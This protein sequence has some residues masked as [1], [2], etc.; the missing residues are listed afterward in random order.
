MGDLAQWVGDLPCRQEEPEFSPQ[1]L[2]VVVQ[3]AL[4]A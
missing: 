2:S 4:E 1:H 3:C